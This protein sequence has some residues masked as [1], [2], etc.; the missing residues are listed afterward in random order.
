MGSKE[1]AIRYLKAVE[2]KNEVFFTAN[3][4]NILDCVELIGT[5][6]VSVRVVNEELPPDIVKEIESMFWK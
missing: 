3:S 2:R 1:F 5:S 4:L 6:V